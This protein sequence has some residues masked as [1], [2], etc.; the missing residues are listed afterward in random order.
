MNIRLR[1]KAGFTLIELLVVIAIIGILASLI[2]PV[3]SRA[4]ESARR[5]QCASNIRQLLT[6]MYMYS[7]SPSNGGTLPT[8]GQNIDDS[9]AKGTEGLHLLYRQ[10][11]NDPRIYA[12]PSDPNRPAPSKLQEL[13]G[14]PT[15]G[16]QPSP[17]MD[18]SY[19]SYQYD[20]GHSTNISSMVALIA[21]RSLSTT[22]NSNSHGKNAGQNV[23]FGT[24][25]EFR[26]SVKNPL[27]EGAMDASIYNVNDVTAGSGGGTPDR[28]EDSYIRD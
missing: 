5:T 27:G 2:L 8:L 12:C 26:E 16:A 17:K 3:L 20:P 13:P 19:T 21:D 11:V 14:W 15:D 4:R 10:Y 25:V 22:A 18:K 23:G 6:A 24:S 9:G 7:D 28:N 1:N